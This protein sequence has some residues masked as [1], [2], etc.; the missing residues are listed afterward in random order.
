MTTT[1]HPRLNSEKIGKGLVINYPAHSLTSA[2]SQNKI[3]QIV[4]IQK[5]SEETVTYNTPIRFIMLE[6]RAEGVKFAKNHRVSDQV[7]CFR[8]VCIFDNLCWIFILV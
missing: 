2:S 6:L 3:V 8:V 4:N 7:N 1:P 5:H